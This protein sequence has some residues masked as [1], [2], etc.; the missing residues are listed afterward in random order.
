MRLVNLFKAGRK[1]G[2]DR[3]LPQNFRAKRVDCSEMRFFEPGHSVFQEA[4]LVCIF[5][6]ESSFV[7]FDAEP[8]AQLAR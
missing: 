7:E 3:T 8:Q 4:D 6:G 2:F 5:R 1:P